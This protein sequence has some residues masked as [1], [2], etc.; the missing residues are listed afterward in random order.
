MNLCVAESRFGFLAHRPLGDVQA[1]WFLSLH[2]VKSPRQG[3]A[4]SREDVATIS[5]LA[6][7]GG[8]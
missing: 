4:H 1:H 8:G 3:L 6:M 5:V 2:T 7:G